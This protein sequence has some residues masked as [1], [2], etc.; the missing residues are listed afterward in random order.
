[1]IPISGYEDLIEYRCKCLAKNSDYNYYLT[2]RTF[3]S[4]TGTAF[5]LSDKYIIRRNLSKAFRF[6]FD[7]K[8]RCDSPED[9]RSIRCTICGTQLSQ[10]LHRMFCDEFYTAY[11]TGK[12]KTLEDYYKAV[13]DGEK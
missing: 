13:D 7:N 5:Y 3:S 11:K 4:N 8:F 12:M 6:V 1:M 2:V 9:I 10:D